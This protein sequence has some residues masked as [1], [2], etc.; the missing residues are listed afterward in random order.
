MTFKNERNILERSLTLELVRVTEEAALASARW[1]GRG[2]QNSADDAATTAMRAVLET[3]PMQGS[4]VIGE[5]EMDEAPMLYIG[6]ELGT[7]KGPKVDVAVDPLEGTKID[8]KSTRLNS[9]H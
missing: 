3:I 4:V 5:G 8:R 2:Q 7:G 9:S 6:E 1:M